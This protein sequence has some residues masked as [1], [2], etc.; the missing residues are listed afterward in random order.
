MLE[1]HNKHDVETYFG[2]AE[3]Y[4]KIAH[5]WAVRASEECVIHTLEGPVHANKGD[6]ILFGVAC[7]EE[8]WPVRKDIFETTYCLIN[9]EGKSMLK[10]IRLIEEPTKERL[11]DSIEKLMQ[12]GYELKDVKVTPA[13][14][15]T[16]ATYLATLTISKKEEPVYR[17][18]VD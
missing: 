13:T 8:I 6:M 14:P 12:Q 2:N 4:K 7:D 1:L 3:K 15:Y 10:P 11:E 16:N 17:N 5:A 18:F 9:E